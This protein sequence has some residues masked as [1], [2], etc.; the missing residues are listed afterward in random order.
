M[1]KPVTSKK[2]RTDW[3]QV[4]TLRDDKI[5]FSVSPELTPKM[6]ARAIVRRGLK[7]AARKKLLTPRIDGDAV[8]WY[9]SQGS[10][11]QTRINA[12][13]CAYTVERKNA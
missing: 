9:R 2:S 8:E 13:L 10:G 7:P 11:F 5:D 6:F 3:K 4:G 1:K 12:L